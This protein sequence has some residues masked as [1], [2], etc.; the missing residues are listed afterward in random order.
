MT[1]RAVA[2]PTR[3]RRATPLATVRVPPA[4]WRRAAAVRPS[5]DCRGAH[6]AQLCGVVQGLWECL[7]RAE[8]TIHPL[9]GIVQALSES[10]WGAERPASRLVPSRC[11]AIIPPPPILRSTAILST[12]SRLSDATHARLSP[13]PPFPTPDIPLPTARKLS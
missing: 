4:L 9:C 8:T 3:L 7:R 1:L 12:L 13:V 10:L 2:S 11:R 6:T 5:V